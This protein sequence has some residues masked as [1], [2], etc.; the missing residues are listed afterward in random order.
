MRIETPFTSNPLNYEEW[1]LYQLKT[2]LAAYLGSEDH[3]GSAR[4][5]YPDLE[6]PRIYVEIEDSGFTEKEA[7]DLVM[8][9][10]H[11]SPDLQ[12]V[13]FLMS[14]HPRL[15]TKKGALIPPAWTN[16]MLHRISLE[17]KR[18]LMYHPTGVYMRFHPENGKGVRG[19]E[20][21]RKKHQKVIRTITSWLKGK[22]RA[23][24]LPFIVRPQLAED[25][26]LEMETIGWRAKKSHPFI[27]G[28]NIPNF[29]MY[30]LF[31]EEEGYRW[32]T[33]VMPK[34]E[35]DA[36]VEVLKANKVPFAKTRSRLH[37]QVAD[38][39]EAMTL[40]RLFYE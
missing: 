22:Y 30:R 25:W 21:L 14:S 23:G 29:F 36:F 40:V 8:K 37:V 11:P 6:D 31:M 13:L 27:M 16:A 17:I 2:N 18:P 5:I 3:Q 12:G 28:E 10:T 38:F 26:G 39:E 1:M 19:S 15:Y 4:V 33:P 32:M 24:Y 7:R 34:E 9:L 20:R 35:E